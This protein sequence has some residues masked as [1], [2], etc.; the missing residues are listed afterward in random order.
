[1]RLRKPGIKRNVTDKP[2][3]ALAGTESANS[4]EFVPTPIGN[5]DVYFNSLNEVYDFIPDFKGTKK[6]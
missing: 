1:M 3:P 5:E 4:A 6:L 2:D